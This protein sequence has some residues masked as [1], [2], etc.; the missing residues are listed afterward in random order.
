MWVG[1]VMVNSIRPG[2]IPTD[3]GLRQVNKQHSLFAKMGYIA[4]CKL[5]NRNRNRKISFL[6]Y[7]LQFITVIV[8]NHFN[9]LIYLF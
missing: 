6:E 5:R 9:A 7:I 2:S 8:S 3:V 1:D 4:S